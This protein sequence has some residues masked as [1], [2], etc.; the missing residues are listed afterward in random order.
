MRRLA[1][2]LLAALA[3]AGCG[4]KSDPVTPQTRIPR[5]VSTLS[6]SPRPG[7]IDVAWTNPTRRADGARL[8]DLA[9]ARVYRT[10][11]EGDAPPRAAMLEGGRVVGWTEIASL[12]LFP[13]GPGTGE[14]AKITDSSDLVYGRRYTYVVVTADAQGRTS[15]PS[16]RAVVDYAAAPEAPG[17][18]TAEAGD[19]RVRLAWEPPERLLD[20]RT[21]GIPITYEI[22]RSPS[23]DGP[24]TPLP[25]G[26]IT[27]TAYAD[28]S[29]DN[30]TTYS[31]AVRAVRQEHATTI[32]GPASQ[33]VAATPVK[34]SAPAPPTD[35]VA[36]GSGTAVR[37][38]WRGS[39][40]AD[41][42]AYVV[43]RAAGRGTFV[44]VGSV[45]APTT[46]FVDRDVPAG[47]YRY[48]VTAQDASSRANESAR[49]NE[50]SVS[51]P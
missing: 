3:A 13:P 51:L 50:V 22:L 30:D 2:L 40:D 23:P 18:L 38:A 16:N 37:L 25:T 43:Y 45:R 24:L 15:L 44:R 32:R 19:H 5:P 1:L 4:Q 31:Y 41:V 7:A 12:S 47:V 6:A 48:A 28:T 33:R 21:Y 49:S 27:E 34:T 46:T 39:P 29:A 35:L 8:Y 42:A 36:A 9:V 10:A 11:D 14:E 17:G 20:G 26:P